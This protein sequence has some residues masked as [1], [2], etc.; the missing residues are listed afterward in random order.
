MLYYNTLVWMDVSDY[1]KYGKSLW[2]QKRKLKHH[3]RVRHGT[4]NV[5]AISAAQLRDVHFADTH[6]CTS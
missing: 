6:L 5:F 4:G 2:N 1:S 3:F